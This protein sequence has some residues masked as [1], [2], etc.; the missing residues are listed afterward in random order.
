MP[1]RACVSQVR[2][3]IIYRTFNRNSYLLR[4]LK[5]CPLRLRLTQRS[6]YPCADDVN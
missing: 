2:H 6:L 5:M 1:L 4:G 3:P